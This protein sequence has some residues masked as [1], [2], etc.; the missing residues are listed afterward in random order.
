MYPQRLL[1]ERASCGNQQASGGEGSGENA[2]ATPRSDARTS[3][4]DQNAFKRPNLG[5][6]TV[7]SS[8][9]FSIF[10]CGRATFFPRRA[11]R[12]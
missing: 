8:E 6:G 12:Q 4:D 10:E 1:R 7:S 9:R 3:G 2:H 5:T 11:G